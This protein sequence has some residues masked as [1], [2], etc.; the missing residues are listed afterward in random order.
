MI[1][2]TQLLLD[3]EQG[4]L[5]ALEQ[6][7]Q[8]YGG[9]NRDV[10]NALTQSR[11]RVNNLRNM[12]NNRQ[13]QI[14]AARI[15]GGQIPQYVMDALY[16]SGLLQQPVQQ[17]Q[18][19][20][21]QQSMMYQQAPVI[22]Q[23]N[24]Y[25]QPMYN[26]MAYNQNTVT[27]NSN[28]GDRYSRY[29]DSNSQ[30]F[31]QPMMQQPMQQAPVIQPQAVYQQP[32]QAPVV[33]EPK[34][35]EVEPICAPG[36]SFVKENGSYRFSGNQSRKYEDPFEDFFK[37]K[38]L[39]IDGD[40]SWQDMR[41]DYLN[42]NNKADIYK[43]NN[44]AE[45]IVKDTELET[46]VNYMEDT[47]SI[48]EATTLVEIK[49]YIDN[50][51]EETVKSNYDKYITSYVNSVLEDSFNSPVKLDSFIQDADVFE[52]GCYK[53]DKHSLNTA[54]KALVDGIK[55]M[56]KHN[57]KTKRK[58]KSEELSKYEVLRI[59]APSYVVT[60]GDK[61]AATILNEHDENTILSSSSYYWL[62]KYLSSAFSKLDPSIFRIRVLL[63]TSE[64]VVV[65][66]TIDPNTYNVKF[67]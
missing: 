51:P 18:Q 49:D 37:E 54:R 10:A 19:P 48:E 67:K 57:I 38:L 15:Y 6:Q 63:P 22:Q 55:Y 9:S 25:Q 13:L 8:M 16:R 36:I 27:T 12:I 23:Q 58:S 28:N 1:I 50:I 32:A 31:Q 46:I 14:D 2:Q 33:E 52:Q 64:V 7:N 47:S 35:V 34:V 66:K 39:D 3:I 53:S 62:Y 44:N 24:M 43:F 65:C 4:M 45:V 61:E 41:A 17:Y 42:H 26:N 20:M 11:Y 29:T 60:L 56:L 5:S 59:S 21:V 30:Q 40:I